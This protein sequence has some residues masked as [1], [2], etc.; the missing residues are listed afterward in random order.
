MLQVVLD[1]VAAAAKPPHLSEQR[2]CLGGGFE[3]AG[4]AQGP[5][6]LLQQSAARC[7]SPV[8]WSADAYRKSN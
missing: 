6:R 8:T 4:C 3:V 7:G 2:V 1:V 5:S